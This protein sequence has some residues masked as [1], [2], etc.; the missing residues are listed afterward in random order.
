MREDRLKR[1]LAAIL[2]ADVK[3]YSRLM[4]QDEVATIRTLT[5]YRE[6]ISDLIE[7]YQ[8]R[9]VDSPGDNLL[10]DFASVVNAVTC[11]VEIQKELAQRNVELPADRKMRFRIGINLGDV[12]Q[13][14][15][16]IYGDGVNIAARLEGKADV[17]GICISGSAY[18]QVR[19]KLKLGYESLGELRV[20][21][22]A[23]PVRA[24]RVLMAPEKE[25]AAAGED[26]PRP[27]RSVWVGLVIVLAVVL[28]AVA[29]WTHRPYLH[30]GDPKSDLIATE[31]MAVALPDKPSLAVLPFDNLSGDP[32]QEYFSDG[33]TDD[34][35]TDLSKVSG[36]L[37]IARNSTF[38]Y[39]GKAINVQQIGRELDAKYVLEGSVR[40]V[41]NRARINAQLIDASTGAH[42]WADRYDHDL[43]DVFAVQDQVT[44]KIVSALKVTLTEG[45]QERI[46][47]IYTDS[48]EAYD[49][50]LRG[51]EFF[52]RFTKES[53]AEARKM[54]EKAIEIDP[55]YALAYSKLG[56]THLMD[57]IFGWRHDPQSIDEAFQIAQKAMSL[58]RSL[59]PAC[60]LLGH[61]YL[62]KK[63]HALA[64]AEKEKAIALNPNSADLYADLG[65]ILAW[66]GRPEEAIGLVEK[67]MRLNPHYPI[68]YLF[69]LGHAYFLADR[70]EEAITTLERVLN[71]NPRF[72]PAHVY[73]AATY[74]KLG[75]EEEAR[76]EAQRVFN[77]DDGLSIDDWEKRLPYKDESV[78]QEVLDP[79]R[80]AKEATG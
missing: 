19:N 42:L 27:R 54:L 16:R 66:A 23:A 80:K 50:Y 11:A 68:Y 55:D 79:L 5:T 70:Y 64:I 24:Y 31:K 38:I 39:K 60:S 74:S 12:I 22:I 37:V 1:K 9:V 18:D 47:E 76:A 77:A 40:K 78:L 4:G 73:L 13:E 17:G 61:V 7:R 48:L 62:W 20:K 63:E 69:T 49:F 21:N 58:E 53:N 26:A 29:V 15:K 8:G 67:A 36:I 46:K 52:N 72:W 10:A 56:F 75:R 14:A 43:K 2:S 45:E 30:Q 35:I 6:A 71:R 34:L 57:W 44:G 32:Q 25:N 28:L 65:E 59:S 3:G 51:Q 41:G 33:M